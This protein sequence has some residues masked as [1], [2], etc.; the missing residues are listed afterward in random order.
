MKRILKALLQKLR[1]LF[2]SNKYIKMTED[3]LDKEPTDEEILAMAYENAYSL[4]SGDRDFS[5]MSLSP[6]INESYLPFDP[7]SIMSKDEFE[8]TK[9][10]MLDWFADLDEFEK[11][12]FI[13]DYSYAAYIVTM[14]PFDMTGNFRIL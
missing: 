10:S 6:F 5:D 13:R 12:I 8:K 11:C 7:Y 9:L 2:P 3:I 1:A 14:E 4:F